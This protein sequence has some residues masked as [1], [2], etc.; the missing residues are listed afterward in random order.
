MILNGRPS[1]WRDDAMAGPH[2]ANAGESN[3]FAAAI[4]LFNGISPVPSL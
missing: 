2:A 1:A 4:F 3:S